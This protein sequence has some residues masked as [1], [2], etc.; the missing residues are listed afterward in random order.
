MGTS[1]QST[2]NG[3]QDY[4]EVLQ[5]SPNAD[6]YTLSR[7]YR[8]LVKRYHPD[9]QDT[10]NPDKFREIVDAYRVL[11]DPDQRAAYD[12]TYDAGRTSGL[13]I[14][15]EGCTSDNFEVDRRIFEGILSLLYAARRREP[16][17]GGMGVIQLER[18]LACPAEHLGF[19]IWYLLEKNWIIRQ[20]NGQLAITVT[21][22]DRMREE[23]ALLFQRDHMIGDKSGPDASWHWETARFR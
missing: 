4:Y 14:F 9:N 11:S 20:N 15:E 17:R 8:V 12:A 2:T 3:F 5:L 13:R 19:H 10:G 7:V 22:I 23:N 21:G 18:L 1:A 6:S 16:A